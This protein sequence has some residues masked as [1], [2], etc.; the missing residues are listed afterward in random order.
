ME[1][2]CHL[3]LSES[4]GFIGAGNMA[5]AIGEG[6]LN[7]GSDGAAWWIKKWNSK[8]EGCSPEYGS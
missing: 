5:K 1:Q 7:A 8:Y 3:Q 4:V 6:M 2:K